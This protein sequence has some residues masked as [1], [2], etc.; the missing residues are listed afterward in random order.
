MLNRTHRMAAE[1]CAVE[2]VSYL[3][4]NAASNKREKRWNLVNRILWMG[5]KETEE[6]RKRK[7]QIKS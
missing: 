4:E 1:A 3:A 6:G 7:T 2:F 5:G